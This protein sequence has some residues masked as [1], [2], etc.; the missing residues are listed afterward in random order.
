MTTA[1]EYA[2]MAGVSYRSTRDPKNRFQIPT[3]WDETPEFY[4]SLSSGF[5][6]ATFTNGTEIVISFAGTG[7]GT[8][9]WIYGNIPLASG[10]LSD[11]LRQ[12]ADYYLQVKASAPA[13]TPITF[14]GHSLGGG[15]AS[16]MAVFFGGSAFT[17][18]QAPFRA[19]ALTT[20]EIDINT[21][22]TIYH[23]ASRDLRAYLA[24]KA[25][26]NGVLDPQIVSLLAP[27]DAYIT[28]TDP[29][30]TNPIA[31]D[32]LAYREARVTDMNVQGEIL[33]EWFIPFSRIGAQADI[34]DN[35]NGVAGTDLHSQALLTAY[36]Q[37]NKS[38]EPFK[39]LSD[40]TFKLTDLLKMIFD[41]KLYYNDPNSTDAPV[42]E[43]FLERLVKHEAG[44]QGS[45]AADTM[46]TRFTSD[47]W[48]LAQDGGMTLH[49]GNT[50][51]A[52]HDLSNA[53]M[54]FAMQKYYEEKT[55][56]AGYKK[57]LFTD[58][59]TEGGS[60]GIRFDVADVS[61]K[62]A[63]A[64][65]HNEKFDLSEKDPNGNYYLKG[66]KNFEFYLDQA[67]NGFT[68]EDRQLINSLLPYMRDWYVQ[69]GLPGMIASDANGFGSGAFMLGG[70][71]DDYLTGGT[72]ADLL[73]GNAGDDVLSGGMGNDLLIG[74]AGN[75]TYRYNTGDGFDT[76]LDRDGNGS[77]IEDGSTLAGGAQYGDTRVH[78]DAN[79]HLF[80]DVGQGRLVID[81]NIL[82]QNYQAGQ[83]GLA[84]SGAEQQSN[85]QTTVTISANGKPM[86]F[87]KQIMGANPNLLS[88]VYVNTFAELADW[89]L[90]QYDFVAGIE[91]GSYAADK[92]GIADVSKMVI[93][94]AQPISGVDANGKQGQVGIDYTYLLRD[95]N[96]PTQT[97]Y[98]LIAGTASLAESN[99]ALINSPNNDHII[100]SEGRDIVPVE[101]VWNLVTLA[102]FGNDLIET[103]GGNDWVS[104][105]EGNDVIAGGSGE[106]I[107]IGGA[108]DD[109]MY[110][111]EQIDIAQ[112]IINGNK[113]DGNGEVDNL[114][115]GSGNDTLVGDTGNDWIQG[116][117]GADLLIGGAGDD[118][119]SGDNLLYWNL[120]SDPNYPAR[121][122]SVE[123]FGGSNYGSFSNQY[124]DTP[125]DGAADVIY[126]GNGKDVVWGGAGNDII[127]GEGGSDRLTGDDGNDIILGGDGNDLIYGDGGIS[128]NMF[129]YSTYFDTKGNYDSLIAGNDY[130][131]GGA[132]DDII[133]GGG[134]DD[135]I[136]GGT[137]NNTLY[138]GEGKDTYIFERGSK[139]TVYDDGNNIFRFGDGFDP[140]TLILREGSLLLDFG[141]GDEVH[142]MNFD[143]QDAYNSL[144]GASFEFADGTALSASQLLAKGFDITGTADDDSIAGTSATDRINGLAGNDTLSG[145]AGDDTL[146]G[147]AGNDALSGGTGSDAYI[148]NRGDGQDVISDNGDLTSRDTLQFAAD[149]LQ[150]DVTLECQT[151]GD[152]LVKING[153]LDQI[154]VAG[155]YTSQTNGIER[156]VF[157]DGVDLSAQDLLAITTAQ[158]TGTDQN[159][160]LVGSD[161][162]DNIL[163][164]GG[165]DILY[166]GAGNDRLQGGDGNDILYGDGGDDLM[167]GGA[168]DDTLTGGGGADTLQGGA[169]NDTLMDGY[170]LEG[171]DGNDTLVGGNVLDGGEGDD[172][173]LNGAILIG[174]AGNDFMDGGNGATRYLIDPVQIGH[175]LVGDSGDSEEAYKAWYYASL[176]I[177]DVQMHEFWAGYYTSRSMS[178]D[179]GCFTL[180][181]LADSNNWLAEWFTNNPDDLLYIDP[182]PPFVRPA[183][184]DYAALQPLYNA[185]IIPLDTVEFGRG[186]TMADIS[187]SWGKEGEHATL[188]LSWNNGSSQVRVLIP[189]YDD[190]LGMGV[191]QFTFADGTTL[192]M[193]DMMAMA[194]P[195]P[196]F[197]PGLFIFQSGMGAQVVDNS[198]SIIRFGAGI[199]AGNIL[200]FQQGAD[201]LIKS[202]P[203]G[204]S[205]LLQNYVLGGDWGNELTTQLQF[206]DGSAGVYTTDGQGIDNMVVT[207]A[208]GNVVADFWHYSDGFY[209]ND[210][211]NADGTSN[212]ICY[213]PD[214]SYSC[215]YTDYG[216][217]AYNELDFNTD[218]STTYINNDGN[219]NWIEVDYDASGVKVADRWQHADYTHGEDVFN[220]D[221][222]SSGAA[223]NADNSYS[224]YIND[225]YG[226]VHTLNY[227]AGGNLLGTNNNHAPIVINPILD[228]IVN[229]GQVFSFG[230]TNFTVDIT[231][232]GTPNK[233]W[234]DPNNYI[235][236]SGGNDVYAFARG[237]G[238]V[239]IGDWDN[240]PMDIV[241]FVN[242]L[243]SDVTITQSKWGDAVL[244]LNGAPDSLTLGGGTGGIEKVVF[245]DNS[246]WAISY[247]TSMLSKVPSSGSDQIVIGVGDNT[248]HALSGDDA[249]ITGGGNDVLLGGSGNDLLV[250]GGGSDILIGGSGADE[251]HAE[252]DSF[253]DRSNDLLAGGAGADFLLASISSD[254]LIG[255]QGDDYIAGY[256]GN[257]VVLFNRGDGNDRVTAST[258]VTGAKTDTLSLGGGISYS[259]LSFS[260]IDYRLVLNVGNSESIVF[261]EWL[262]TWYDG[263][264]TS[265]LQIITEAMAGYDPDAADPL[266][267][268]RI[269][270]FDFV[271]LAKQFEDAMSADSSITT[272]EIAPHL[273]AFSLGGSNTTAL[274]G[275]MAYVYGM[276]GNLKSLSEEELRSQLTDAQ[277]GISAQALSKTN[278]NFY[279]SGTVFADVDT[280]HGD[281]LTFTATLADGSALPDWLNFASATQVFSGTPPGGAGAINISIMATD[282]AGLSA[283]SNFV[284]NVEGSA[285]SNS[286]PLAGIIGDQVTRQGATFEFNI[287]AGS[288]NDPDANDT[289]TYTAKLAN[290]TP[291]PAWMTFDPATQTLSGTAG[292]ADVAIYNI[293]ITA[294]DSAGLSASSTFAV[295]VDN[296][297]DAPTANADTSATTDGAGVVQLTEATLLAN[298]TDP[299]SIHGDVLNIVGVSQAA[300][301]AAVSLLNGNVQYD[302][303]NL[304]QSIAHG[305]TATDTFSY[306]V[307]DSAGATSTATVT[308][309]VSGVNDAAVTADDASSVQEDVTVTASGNV[310][311]NDSDIDQDTVLTVANAGTLQGNYGQLILNEDGNYSYQ[312][313]N[314]SAAVQGL[315]AGQV[316]TETF[317]YEA[318]DGYVST[319][320]TLTVTVTGTNDGPVALDDSATIDEDRLLN[321]NVDAL[322]ANDT[323]VDVGDSK[324]LASVAAASALGA[325]VSLVPATG[326]GQAAQIVYDHGGRFNS[327]M[328]GQSIVDSFTYTMTDSAG[329]LS[330]ATVNVTVVGVNDG[331]TAHADSASTNED[332]AQT[333]ISTAGLLANDTDPDTGDTFALAGFDSV[334]ALGNAISM[335][336][337]GKLVFDIG[338]RY[339]YLAQGQTITDTFSYTITDTAGALSTAQVTMTI[340]GN[341]DAP[342]TVE[343]LASVQE[344]VT[345]IVTGNVLANDADVDQGAILT[346]ANAAVLAGSYGQLDLSADGRYSYALNSTSLAVQSLAA[347]QVVTETFDYQATDGMIATPATLTVTITGTNDAPVVA[348]QLSNQTATETG[349]FV[350]Q[351]PTNTFTDIDQGDTLTY[352]AT[353]ADGAAL[354][355]WLAFDSSTMSFSSNLIDGT[356]GLWEINVTATDTTGASAS[357]SFTL[358][359]AKLIKGSCED[360]NM[361]GTALRDVMYGLN[362]EDLLRGYAGDDI[363]VGGNGNDVLEGGSGNDTLIGGNPAESI[364]A[365]AP[366]PV[367]CVECGEGQEDEDD[368][369]DVKCALDRAKHEDE[370]EDGY[371]R[372]SKELDD[373]HACAESNP[374]NNMLNGGA[375][376]DTLTG[377]AQND[378]LI[379]GTGNDIIV[380]GAGRDIIAFNK[381]DGQDTVLAPSTGSGQAGTADNTLSLGGGIKISDLS[382]RHLG[383]DLVLETGAAE[384]IT[385]SDWYASSA[386]HSIVNLQLIDTLATKANKARNTQLDFS[387]LVGYFDQAVA[388]NGTTDR[389]AL[390][391][392]LLDTHLDQSRGAALGG[393]LAYQYGHGG[394]LTTVSLSASQDIMESSSFGIKTQKLNDLPKFKDDIVMLG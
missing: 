373:E 68:A 364:F 387:A 102:G 38:A 249:V 300:S 41:S 239:Y 82:V 3:G 222:S 95:E 376:N 384:Q 72:G 148:F 98:S 350:Y 339:Q 375:G 324:T 110:A 71:A 241:T 25:T 285:S 175:D 138:G 289:L 340:V 349:T 117:G 378:L 304:F 29:A 101:G 342:V 152:L 272:W 87:H 235:F 187:L 32:T 103:K 306:T 74:G 207:D 135:I 178:S 192:R 142:F 154:T 44:V 240:S 274:G 353:M 85:P 174:G 11:Q 136:L 206:A 366:V 176:G 141:N 299:D 248:I 255:G 39:N 125:P 223:Y 368:H 344:D 78:R 173:L 296:V 203:Q 194:P 244:G 69:A 9:D 280:T 143:R 126:A 89:L 177:Q 193:S 164:M 129:T 228:Q 146:I 347:G 269:Q 61:Y 124:S 79:G 221:G 383:N 76:I 184:N 362:D 305:Q 137:G 22:A 227:D 91:K 371:D 169:G 341:N 147:G 132:D 46:V 75:D 108:G 276:S 149:I 109:R 131:D 361:K 195:A 196:T 317:N 252:Q 65:S 128:A 35:T 59:S 273:A 99:D 231:D 140:N 314:S 122:F 19:S 151:N 356:A 199:A 70:T 167:D 338:N 6:A 270:Q 84:M 43:N 67:N 237:N 171:G 279:S 96:A 21:S 308:M 218:G 323:D 100:G 261:P 253:T 1:I 250:G 246:E 359:V 325:T 105:G 225:G 27:L 30:N 331:P 183:A 155:Q 139:N 58:I 10:N 121:Q 212:G 355:S 153:S 157:G 333:G 310:L 313:D 92:F 258:F 343:D 45:I 229:A 66:Y 165:D 86:E 214:G 90:T 264:T 311:A 88:Y 284:L 262:M 232:T 297:N 294:T 112:A 380:T 23:S 77:I 358:D 104:G 213:Y 259:D 271:G 382:F 322:L 36:L 247:I 33:S 312:L 55:T 277:F 238:N 37:S 393:D 256:D 224:T 181:E 4:R 268:K 17:F 219:F 260:R 303:G 8:A 202:G 327:L 198:C 47:L 204:D 357:S 60:G 161:F 267:N 278:G 170:L 156:I 275:D 392:A 186:I 158:I 315:M 160:I 370:H 201:L 63:L 390:T 242:L 145:M 330:T 28:A 281:T 243:P 179:T 209:G 81:G 226:N 20:S 286:S 234:A 80:V 113:Q 295:N 208:N 351:M 245:A 49:D 354:P 7:P 51:P 251:I 335:D 111:N 114:L 144:N 292:N 329:A 309:T 106:D 185:G 386:N 133:Y 210:T 379:G 180:Q 337:D 266:L 326:S 62:L 120:K 16:L 254:L 346:V 127:F 163:G 48:K 374:G 290:N 321:V 318:Y 377:G 282:S 191:E 168:G 73:V 293:T 302:I 130:L 166:G 56:S 385:F 150:S 31:A 316:V 200:L 52:V 115:G 12:A 93:V 283:T 197:D 53:L 307:S 172:T 188:D 372:D 348:I 116:G 107:L 119:I 257:N 83:L 123:S 328:A 40:V 94:K 367:G 233:L 360:D 215:T 64:A 394:S 50:N 26:V 363:L 236:G 336:A 263:K 319:P 288:F 217:G 230:P 2:L 287:P 265:R 182:L 211:F 365:G 388:V 15:L 34:P 54:A 42:K 334:S 162:A 332:T 5:E 391:N 301:G 205:V 97:N 352:T 24:G 320:A 381:G 14:T 291:L 159:D 220:A 189:H 298:D 13:G 216:N 134:G 18:D 369:E 190:P 118:D 389:W 345:V 57:E